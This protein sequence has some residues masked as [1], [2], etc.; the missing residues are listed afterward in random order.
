MNTRNPQIAARLVT[1]L[2][3]WRRYDAV[4]QGQMKSHLERLLDLPDLSKDVYEIVSK[5]LDGDKTE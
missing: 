3:R 5:S 2:S 4:R 1:G